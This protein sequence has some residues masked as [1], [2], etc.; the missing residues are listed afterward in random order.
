MDDVTIKVTRR[1][2]SNAVNNME[3]NYYRY[4]TGRIYNGDNTQYRPFRFVVVAYGD[5][6]WE[7]TG[8]QNYTREDIFR[9]LDEFE[10][11][12]FDLIKGFDGDDIADFYHACSVSLEKH[13]RSFRYEYDWARALK[14]L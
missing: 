1:V 13:Y 6:I 11:A 3:C 2:H 12:I 7:Y 9:C 8:N 4:V 10:F 5:D 14:S